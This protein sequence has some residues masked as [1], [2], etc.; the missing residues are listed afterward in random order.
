VNAGWPW[1]FPILTALFGL[2]VL[3]FALELWLR[4]TRVTV[5]RGSL[6]WASGYLAP[7]REHTLRADQIAN[8]TVTVGMTIGTTA[9]HDVT[10]VPKKGANIRL[11]QS[12]RHKSEAERLAAA[13]RNQLADGS[14]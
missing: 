12:L 9:Y 5:R 6:A 2:F 7:G 1:I 14:E 4:V 10:V 8:V 11:A 3:V 13:I